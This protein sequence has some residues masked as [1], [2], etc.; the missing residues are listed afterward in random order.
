MA[1]W[2]MPDLPHGPLRALNCELHALHRKAGYPSARELHL[3]VDQAVSHTKIHHAFTR[4][5]LPTWGVVELVVEQLA[6]RARPRL[7]PEAEIDRF[8]ALWDE[9]HEPGL[10]AGHSES[11]ETSP[12]PVAP[13]ATT[14]SEQS[15][16]VQASPA[17]DPRMAFAAELRKLQRTPRK[18]PTEE[19]LARRMGYGRSTVAAILNGRRFPSWESTEAF[20]KACGADPSQGWR[21]LWLQTSRQIEEAGG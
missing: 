18:A 4:A 21:K 14:A 9:V 13:P 16:P 19:A 8:K 17:P 15:P 10:E 7:D 20:V 1:R 12:P 11:V 2:R 3:A 6:K 5:T